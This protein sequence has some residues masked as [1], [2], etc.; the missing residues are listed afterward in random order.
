MLASKSFLLRA[1]APLLV[2]RRA[3]SEAPTIPIH[4]TTRMVR[5]QVKDEAAALKAQEILGKAHQLLKK[6]GKGYVGATRF[7]CKSTTTSWCF[8][9]FC[10]FG[11]AQGANG[12][13]DVRQEVYTPLV[14]EL[15]AL[16]V[17]GK[18]HKPELYR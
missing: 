13:R 6:D 5:L 4:G 18:V 2:L 11:L 10:R 15:N 7:L 3:F 1:R 17:N 12:K 9:P 8:F 16:D 14:D